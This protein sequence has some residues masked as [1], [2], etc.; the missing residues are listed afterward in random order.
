MSALFSSRLKSLNFVSLRLNPV[1]FKAA[2][3]KLSHILTIPI[4]TSVEW[5]GV[6]QA[7]DSKRFQTTER[8]SAKHKCRMA[9]ASVVYYYECRELRVRK[10][11]VDMHNYIVFVFV[12]FFLYVV[13]VFVLCS[14][15]LE[16]NKVSIYL[17]IY[18]SVSMKSMLNIPHGSSL[19]DIHTLFNGVKKVL[20]S[21]RICRHAFAFQARKCVK[22][23][24]KTNPCTGPRT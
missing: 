1:V 5:I 4:N 3:S 18:L 6:G 2:H 20:T 12:R 17:S 19:R 13:Y 16:D 11:F 14:P 7:C 8:R 15:Y 23:K 9:C 21:H 24:K 22:F 10:H